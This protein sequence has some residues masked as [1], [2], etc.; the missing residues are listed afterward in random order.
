[1]NFKQ[2]NKLNA[3]YTYI[4]IR[5]L[6]AKQ[7]FS[8]IF[9]LFLYIVFKDNDPRKRFLY[10]VTCTAKLINQLDKFLCSSSYALRIV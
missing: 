2:I 6:T 3:I 9:I 7:S 8:P 4:F 5:F 1:M 10:S